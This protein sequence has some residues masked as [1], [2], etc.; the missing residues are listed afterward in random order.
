MAGSA[1]G[2]DEANI[3]PSCLLGISCF[4]PTKARFFYVIFWPYNKS[5]FSPSLFSQD[6]WILPLVNNAYIQLFCITDTEY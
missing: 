3:G 6:G 4:V 2:Q 5:F 1:S